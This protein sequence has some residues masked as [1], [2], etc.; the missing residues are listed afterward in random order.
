MNKVID[1]KNNT[2]NFSNEKPTLYQL[3]EDIAEDREILKKKPNISLDTNGY[4]N[5]ESST[6]LRKFHPE[7]V[8]YCPKIPQNTGTIARLCAAFSCT[9]HLIE[10]LGFKISDKALRRAGLDYWQ[11]V[12][13]ILHK[14]WDDFIIKKKTRRFIFIETGCAERPENFLFMPGDLIVFGAETHGIPKEIIE[15]FTSHQNG[16]KLTIPMFNRGVRSINL[17]NSVSIVLYTA[18]AQLNWGKTL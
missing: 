2:L 7:I 5:Q 9:L 16:S 10:P 6:F 8:L 18:V 12:E 13:V 11:F 1:S 14:S 17:A 3:G 15:K 4:V